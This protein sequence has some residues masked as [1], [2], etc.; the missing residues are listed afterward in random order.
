MSIGRKILLACAMLLLISISATGIVL[1]TMY[2][3]TLVDTTDTYTSVLV[4]QI[5]INLNTRTREYEDS[6]Y[7]TMQQ[8]GLFGQYFNNKNSLDYHNRGMLSSFVN[9]RNTTKSPV[10]DMYL[11][12][13]EDELYY[14][15]YGSQSFRG[16]LDAVEERMRG[17]KTE[18]PLG[19]RAVW[20]TVP[21]D[22]AAVYLLRCIY[23]VST[24]KYEG[25]VVVG[26]ERSLIQSQ[27]EK[28]ET[29]QNGH[30]LILGQED[31]VVFGTEEGLPDAGQL[32][33]LGEDSAEEEGLTA[34]G[35]KSYIFHCEYTED[36]KWKVMYLVSD[37]ELLGQAR[38]VKSAIATICM[39]SVLAAL[40]C[41]MLISRGITREIR[42]LTS[43]MQQ[44]KEGKWQKIAPPYPR[45]EIGE[46]TRTYNQMV[47]DL[48]QVVRQLAEQ[49]MRTERAQ[50]RALQ[51]EFMELQAMVNPHFIYNAME[52][53]NARAKLAGQEEI[54]W[55]CTRLGRLMRAAIRPKMELIPLEME[56][57]Y[58]EAYLD[59]QKSMMKGRLEVFYD[60]EELPQGYRIPALLL[61]PMVE[62][63]V[64][65]GVEH[66]RDDAVIVVAVS[67]EK[68]FEKDCL[69]IRISDNGAGMDEKTLEGL[70]QMPDN[71]EKVHYGVQSV[72]KRIQICFGE[73]YGVSAE[74][75]PGEGTTF[76]V[77]LPGV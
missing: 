24:L 2:Y 44:M 65:H 68:K 53:I 40:V 19:A 12:D 35:G 33:S 71:E 51:A 37:E 32:L 25:M 70:F 76:T 73:P 17:T 49:L 57:E 28:L 42:H 48:Q 77:V 5:A 66:M 4:E 39:I 31:T 60:F 8:W 10:L 27:F 62:N 36:G 64:I 72:I 55:L 46:I 11:L 43:H 6:I 61:Q 30:L 56:L 75:R 26:I 22:E 29:S 13:Q 21:E 50:Y 9:T 15:N 74:S 23:D 54:S 16:G 47:E 14:Y 38:T 52:S 18:L 59:I 3:R 41:A 20:F 63:A 67:R 34:I 58:V 69:V 7:N 45:D 1:N